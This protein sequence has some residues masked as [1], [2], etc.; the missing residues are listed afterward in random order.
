MRKAKTVRIAGFF[1]A[2]CASAALVGVSVSGT[3]AYFTDSHNGSINVSTGHIKVDVDPADGQL[4]FANLLPAEYQTKRVTYT[5]HPSSGTEDIWL[6]FPDAGNGDAFASVPANGNSPLGRYGH[7]GVTSTGGASFVSSNLSLSNQGGYS[8]PHSCPIDANGEGGSN[9]TA[10]STSDI[11][12]F[13][14]PAKAIL[15]QSGM[16]DGATGY[17]DLTFGFTKLLKS[18][19]DGPGTAL[20]A[21]KIVATQHGIR[22]D[23]VNNG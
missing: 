3:G 14:A 23:D 2:L 9:Q 21:F 1:G 15:L 22:P 10:N 7:F 19:Q 18:G 13:C 4:N 8:D 11:V 5:A 16:S 12:P 20:E 17:A 6:V